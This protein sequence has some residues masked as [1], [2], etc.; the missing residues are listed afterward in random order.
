M[1]IAAKTM[2]PLLLTGVCLLTACGSAATLPE[3]LP[4]VLAASE[5][6][7]TELTERQASDD[8]FSVNY[9]PAGGVNPIRADNATNMQLWSLMYDSVFTVNPDW[10]VS[11]EVVTGWESSDFVW[12]VFRV[13]TSIP[14]TDGTTLTAA[15]VVYSIQRASQTSYYGSR[16]NCIYGISALDEGTFAITTAYANSQFP[17]LLNIPIIKKGAYFEDFP[18]G[19]G[20]YRFSEDGLSLVLFEENRHAAEMPV[21]T[22]G[23]VD[24]TDIS[25]KIR[26]FED[27]RLDIVTNDP[28]GMYSLGYGRSETRYSDT[29]CMHYIGFNMDS[30]FFQSFATRSAVGFAVDREYIVSELLEGCGRTATLPVHPDA[31]LYD[32]EYAARFDYDTGKAG[33]LF[34]NSG[35]KDLDADGEP[36]ILVTGIVVEL[37]V[38]FIVN[39]DS[40]AKVLAAKKICEDLNALGFR[41]TLHVLSWK[42][43]IEALETGD[44]DMYYGE[45]RMTPDWNLSALF[46]PREKRKENEDFAGINYGN[47]RDTKYT[48]YYTAY[49]E[50]A[51]DASRYTA[52]RDVCS[53][54]ADTGIIIP[55]CFERREILTHRNVIS[56]I[57]ATQYDL[58]YNFKDW[59]M[60]LK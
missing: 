48:E 17:A 8:I 33:L 35:V 11:S 38:R 16:L 51:D 56:D 34:D 40:S 1:K 20:P 54:I 37:N 45:I 18:A 5:P 42:D 28:T 39:N 10:T 53:Y 4:D 47:V 13:D 23:L 29:S 49:L 19:S 50:A 15:D 6:V 58:F 24:C 46:T 43:Y 57:T 31:A 30:K 41:T 9:D 14:F 2:I 36:E 21:D 55:V 44:Y 27:S 22:I 25:N 26:Y 59:K 32:E 3:N 52:F 7:G 60:D 12:W